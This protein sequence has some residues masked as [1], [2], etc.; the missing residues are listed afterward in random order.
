MTVQIVKTPAEEA[1]ESAFAAMRDG[2][3]GAAGDFAPALRDAAMATFRELGLPGR[4]VEEWKYT[5]LRGLLRDVPEPIRASG[6]T[7][8]ET[9]L[10]DVLGIDLDEFLAYRIVIADGAFAPELSHF[11]GTDA[12][13]Q[14]L[15]L[16]EALA[17]PPDWFREGFGKVNPPERDASLALN[18]AFMTDGVVIRIADGAKLDRPLHLVFITGSTRRGM[19]T[20][21]NFISVGEGAAATI[22]ETYGARRTPDMLRNAVTEIT[23]G[24]GAEV[25]HLKYQNEG[26]MGL[27]LSSW[28]AAIGPGARYRAFQFSIGAGLAR[29]QIFTRFTGEGGEADVSGAFMVWDEQ[30]A[31][32]TVVIDHAVPHCKSRALFKGVIDDKARGVVQGKIAVHPGAQKTDAN[33]MAH[34]L[35]LSERAEFDAKPEL[36]IYADDVVCGHGATTGELDEDMLFYLRARGLDVNQAQALLTVAFVGEALEKVECAPVR[37]A[38]VARAAAWLGSDKS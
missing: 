6:D 19:V 23:L 29:N 4:R 20:N 31:D 36:E 32:T 10:Y 12:L 21:R 1:L 34:G 5:D 33:L 17:N 9:D 22:L 38:F 18:T 14:V 24:H 15:P 11:E 37:E 28:M 26:R 25:E 13:F 35:M 7:L 30:H 16:S 8:S 27:H 3:S 2:L